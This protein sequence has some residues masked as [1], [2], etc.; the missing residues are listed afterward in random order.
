MNRYKVEY[1]T[2]AGIY[3][4]FDTQEDRWIDNNEM[5]AAL[6]EVVQ[7]RA[8]VARLDQALADTAAQLVQAVERAQEAEYNLHLMTKQADANYKRAKDAE[9][10]LRKYQVVTL[11]RR[12]KSAEP[13]DGDG[14]GPGCE[15]PVDWEIEAMDGGE[16]HYAYVCADHLG[17]YQKWAADD[18]RLP[19]VFELEDDNG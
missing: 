19:M 1:V 6:N 12:C 10:Q 13:C 2:G 9:E 5:V 17:D 18:G 14:S 3:Q 16:S 4:P 15:N 7:L 8:E 11:A